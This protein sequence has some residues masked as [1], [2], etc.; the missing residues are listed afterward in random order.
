MEWYYAVSG[1][2]AGPVSEAQLQELQRAGTINTSTLV[3]R[4]GS[5]L[6]TVPADATGI[7]PGTTARHLLDRADQLGWTAA[8]RMVRPHDLVEADGAWFV[9]S[10]RGPAAI[11]SLDGRALAAAS[12]DTAKIADLLGFDL[13]P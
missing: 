9:S 4:D 2:Q 3:W 11:R 10:I 8:E 1:Q 5:A 7:L 13:T 6:C 12:A